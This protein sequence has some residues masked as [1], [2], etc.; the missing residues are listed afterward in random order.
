MTNPALS[1]HRLLR[2]LSCTAERTRRERVLRMPIRDYQTVMLPLLEFAGDRLEHSLR[3]TI[4]ALADAFALTPEE[5]K[6]L[7]PSGQQEV[8]DNRIGWARTYL[9]KAGLLKKTRRGHYEVKR[10][11]ADYITE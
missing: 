2:A 7:L 6:Q 8:F 1:N 3:E 9:T 10:I 4:D 5:R 11:D